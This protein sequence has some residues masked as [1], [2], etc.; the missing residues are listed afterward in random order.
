[1]TRRNVLAGGLL[2]LLLG[3]PGAAQQPDRTRPPAV[4]PAPAVK[5]PAIEKRKLANGLSLW[6]VE[7]HDVPIV[8]VNL[9]LDSGV[10]DDPT[11][12]FGVASMTTA[13]LMEGAGDRTSLEVADAL[14]FLGADLTTASSFD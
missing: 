4:G 14:D 1:M 5:V 8:Q 9:L 2:V 12:K 7:L 6:M 10:A 13:M 3:V 11:G